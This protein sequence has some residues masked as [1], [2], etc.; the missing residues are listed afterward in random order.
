MFK[1]LQLGIIDALFAAK[2]YV[3]LKWMIDSEL[4]ILGK[5][6]YVLGLTQHVFAM[7]AVLMRNFVFSPLCV[8][9][10]VRSIQVMVER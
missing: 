3:E 2:D 1:N 5:L 9:P 8:S 7:T 10:K 4:L 6:N